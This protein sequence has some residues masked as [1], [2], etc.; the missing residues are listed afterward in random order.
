MR[1]TASDIRQLPQ[2]HPTSL[3]WTQRD[4]IKS[5]LLEGNSITPLEALSL[6]GAYRL[7]AHI[8]V[9]RSRGMFIVTTMNKD[10][11]GRSYAR[12]HIPADLM[13]KN[14]NHY[15]PS[16]PQGARCYA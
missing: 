12:Y 6:F 14:I 4:S 7:A 3:R 15:L 16:T 8:E 11:T 10:A 5:F 9:L 1:F 2:H 13:G